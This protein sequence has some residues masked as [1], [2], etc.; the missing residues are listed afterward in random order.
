MSK[1]KTIGAPSKQGSALTLADRYAGGWFRPAEVWTLSGRGRSQFYRDVQ[2]GLIKI[3]KLGPR[4]A[5]CF[6]PDVKRYVEIPF[7]SPVSEDAA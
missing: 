3:H 4:Q 1:N 5:G 2:A 6:G 7:T